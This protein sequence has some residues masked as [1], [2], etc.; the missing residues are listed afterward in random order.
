MTN[1]YAQFWSTRTVF[2]MKPL[3]SSVACNRKI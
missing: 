3:P 1:T 2:F